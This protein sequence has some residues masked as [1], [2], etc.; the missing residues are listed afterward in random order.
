LHLYKGGVVGTPIKTMMWWGDL[1]SLACWLAK[2][3][4]GSLYGVVREIRMD[5][6]LSIDRRNLFEIIVEFLDVKILTQIRQHKELFWSANIAM[7]ILQ[8]V[9]IEVEYDLLSEFE[10]KISDSSK[11]EA[12]YFRDLF[13]Y[14]RDKKFCQE[15]ID[16]F[17]TTH[18]CIKQ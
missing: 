11:R 8:I 17:F 16:K 6:L 7:I 13:P 9:A 2:S 12:F 10:G 1:L 5:I 18:P 3:K 14:I 15:L 4:S